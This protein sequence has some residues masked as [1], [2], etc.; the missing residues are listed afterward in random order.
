MRNGALRLQESGEVFGRPGVSEEARL[1]G[2]TVAAL[3]VVAAVVAHA[4]T[5]PSRR[6]PQCATEAAA[7]GQAVALAL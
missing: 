1:A 5:P 6:Q 7:P 4:A 3:R 2:V